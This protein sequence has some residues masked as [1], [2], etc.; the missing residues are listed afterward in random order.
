M[1]TLHARKSWLKAAAQGWTLWNVRV[2]LLEYSERKK[3]SLKEECSR[4]WWPAYSLPDFTATQYP[5]TRTLKLLK[6]LGYW[7]L[8]F[9]CHS[10][11]MCLSLQNMQ[12]DFGSFLFLPSAILSRKLSAFSKLGC[13]LLISTPS[14]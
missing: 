7:Y 6:L 5:I 9:P 3:W 1:D 11:S 14:F 12:K 8:G 4:I 2:C 10:L 13:Y